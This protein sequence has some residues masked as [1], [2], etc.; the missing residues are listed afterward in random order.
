MPASDALDH[1]LV[2]RLWRDADA[3]R[4]DVSLETFAA[5]LANALRRSFGEPLPDTDT[6]S[7]FL[8]GLHLSDLALA[9]A[10]DSGH[11]DAWRHFIETY[12]PVLHRS[13]D[14]LQP[15]GGAR[16]L[17]DGLFAELFGV[18]ERGARTS[19][20]RYFHGRSSLA[21]WLR[22]VLAQRHVDRIR[23]GRRTEPLPEPESPRELHA[24][25]AI[26]NP[27]RTRFLA[28]MRAALMVAIGALL[29]PDRFRLACYY[30]RQ[31]TLAQIGRLLGEHE[32]TV[33]RHVARTRRE[34]RT[35]VESH[36]QQ[37]GLAAAEIDECFRSLAED[38]GDLDLGILLATDEPTKQ[39][40]K[41][42]RDVRSREGTA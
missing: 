4:W 13:A 34:I 19:L 23:S 39:P 35:R 37:A 17:A 20:F 9:C 25:V 11:E 12:T 36:L 30:A 33:S 16:D 6:A 21:T 3:Q 27:E 24:P 40:R 31:M 14:V 10:C 32:A 8:R 28:V 1:R 38:P 15:G 2:E 18:T 26:P 42:V 5:A 22:A 7:A 41:I 29:A